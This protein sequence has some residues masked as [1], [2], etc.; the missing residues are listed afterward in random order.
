[1]PWENRGVEAVP[2]KAVYVSTPQAASTVL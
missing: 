2:A 1:L